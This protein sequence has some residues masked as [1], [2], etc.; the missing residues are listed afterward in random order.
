MTS[1]VWHREIQKIFDMPLFC[2]S[3]IYDYNHGM[4]DVNLVDQ[5]RNVYRWDL[6]MRKRKYWWYIMMWCLKIIHANVYLLYKKYMTLHHL[7]AITHLKFNRQIRLAWIDSENYWPKKK[8]AYQ[9]QASSGDSTSSTT[10]STNTVSADFINRYPRFTDKSMCPLYGNILFFLQE[11]EPHWPVPNL[12]KCKLS[13]T[14]LVNG[15]RQEDTRQFEEF[16]TL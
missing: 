13:I 4:N 7:K 8:R 10:Q 14:S 2:L 12:K 3:L 11:S 9:H 15:L 1:Q 6:F 16:F 5:V